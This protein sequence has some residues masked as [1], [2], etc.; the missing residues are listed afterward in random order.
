MPQHEIKVCPRCQAEFECKLGSI[1]LCQCT[2][3]R[4]DESDRTYIREKYEDCLCLACMIAL[5]NERKQKAFERKIRYF[6]NFMNF[7]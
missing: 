6:F 7:K 5:K 1:H 2:A 4:L 3:V